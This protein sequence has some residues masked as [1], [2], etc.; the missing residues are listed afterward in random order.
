LTLRYLVRLNQAGI[1]GPGKA[2]DSNLDW[3]H[4]EQYGEN[5][6]TWKELLAC[7]INGTDIGLDLREGIIRA[8]EKWGRLEEDLKTGLLAFPYWGWCEHCYDGRLEVEWG[9]DSL[10]G[11]RD[12]NGHW[13]AWRI[14]IPL[15]FF[16]DTP[17]PQVVNAEEVVQ[18]MTDKMIPYAGDTLM[19]DYS[20]ENIYS[21]H[22]VKHVAWHLH[23]LSYYQHGLSF[24]DF[25]WPDTVNA[26]TPDHKGMTPEG[27]PKFFNAVTGNNITFA[28]GME[29]GRKI[30]N[31][32]NALWTLQGRHRDMVKFADYYYDTSNNYGWPSP[33]TKGSAHQPFQPGSNPGPYWLTTFEDGTWDYRDVN[34]N[35]LRSLDR[36]K[37]EDFKTSF[38]NLE[39]WDAASG[40]PTRATLEAL[41]LKSV[42]DLLESKGKLGSP[43]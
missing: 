33:L 27:E 1:L 7:M 3:E 14:F 39:G 21:E 28:D 25:M 13:Y 36:A 32:R 15:A 23:Y 16:G 17:R 20:N 18:I 42:A 40:W 29:E 4:M 22:M 2:I 8:A 26:C 9:W 24:C 38:Y 10:L 6:D 43:S 19:L 34:K 41:N 30:W 11:D 12:V 5:I 31:L 35:Q 37:C